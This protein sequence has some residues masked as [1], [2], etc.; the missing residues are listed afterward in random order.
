MIIDRPY[1]INFLISVRFFTLCRSINYPAGEV[2]IWVFGA[3]VG[4]KVGF[5]GCHRD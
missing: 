4:V 3:C 5:N 2:C 1:V